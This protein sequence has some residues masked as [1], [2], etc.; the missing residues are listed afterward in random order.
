MLRPALERVSPRP[1][2]SDRQAI[3]MLVYSHVHKDHIGGS[4]AFKN[5]KDL[6]S[7]RSTP[8]ATS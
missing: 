3:K 6:K 4:V 2:S 1:F 7:L 8:S 5:V